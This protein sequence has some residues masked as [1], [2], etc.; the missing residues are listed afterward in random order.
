M[1]PKRQPYNKLGRT[2]KFYRD[3]PDKVVKKDAKSKEVNARPAQRKKRSELS[4]IRKKAKKN[5]VDTSK[6]DASH[7]KNGIVRKSIKANRG[8]K[9]D[10]KGDRNARGGKRK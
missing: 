2:A 3:N 1:P 4:T 8:S 6:T 10:T 5:G 9:S 7:T